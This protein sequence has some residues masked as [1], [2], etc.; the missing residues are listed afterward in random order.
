MTRRSALLL[1]FA[2]IVSGCYRNTGVESNQPATTLRV[3]ND[4]FNDVNIYVIRGA[5][6]LRLGTALGNS[7]TDMRIPAT[8]IFGPTP[9]S[10]EIDPIA[11]PRQPTTEQITVN[12]GDVVQM[13]IP[14][15]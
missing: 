11:G 6:R 14:P 8:L 3:R 4:A 15:I 12:A 9:L 5:E 2:L 13:T 10:F 7:T 1:A